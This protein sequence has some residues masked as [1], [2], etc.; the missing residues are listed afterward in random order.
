MILKNVKNVINNW[1]AL[2]YGNMPDR[3][4]MCHYSN[5]YFGN[6]C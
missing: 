1:L 4:K 3:Q 5:E 6:L 2:K